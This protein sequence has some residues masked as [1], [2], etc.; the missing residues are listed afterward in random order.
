MKKL[1]FFQLLLVAILTQS[2]SF[3]PP[4][5]QRIGWHKFG[6]TENVAENTL[7]QCEYESAGPNN[8][9]KRADFVQNCM[10]RLGFRY[11]KYYVQ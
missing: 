1:L 11:G 4:R 9:N 6:V 8:A 3:S 7:A 5:Q 2:C 10:M